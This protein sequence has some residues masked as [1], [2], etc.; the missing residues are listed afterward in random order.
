MPGHS[1]INQTCGC[2]NYFIYDEFIV[3]EMFYE[4]YKL[5]KLREVEMSCIIK[6]ITVYM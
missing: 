5:I 2:R 6:I 3:H 1:T 4:K